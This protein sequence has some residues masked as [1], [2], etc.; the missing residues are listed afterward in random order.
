MRLQD[1]GRPFRAALIR[2]TIRDAR[3]SDILTFSHDADRGETLGG[4]AY[5]RLLGS[6][7]EVLASDGLT[8]TDVAHPYSILV[9]HKAW[10]E[11]LSMNRGALVAATRRRLGGGVPGE[12]QLLHTY[13][14]L[15]SRV[16]PRAV[17]TIGAPEDLCRAA[18]NRGIPLIEVL[19]AQGYASLPWG[20]GDR[21]SLDLPA[22]VISFDSVSTGT[23]SALPSA[24]TEIW[25]ISDPWTARFRPNRRSALPLE[26]QGVFN[27]REDPR[28]VV[29]VS[30]QWGYARDHRTYKEFQGI[31]ANGLLPDSILDLI[32]DTV[33][34]H[35]WLL[36]LHPVQASGSI[37]RRH[38]K[39][40]R[41]V[42]KANPNVDWEWATSVPLP[43]ALAQTTHHITMSSMTTYEASALGIPSL[44]LCPTLNSGEV[45]SSLFQDLI[46]KGL[47]QKRRLE[48][49][50][51]LNWLETARGWSP[52]Q[53]SDSVQ[54]TTLGFIE[55]FGIRS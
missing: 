4:R 31:L 6:I 27:S 22:G 5:G 47:A 2:D 45:N 36:R 35:Y 16:Q 40:L 55:R 21:G 24:G 44:L 52:P 39:F 14:D 15:L 29:L 33:Q 28:Q 7:A 26:W 54:F 13:D 32:A 41:Q 51:L 38:R 12:G 17:L 10:G 9:G 8:I 53:V 30:L 37:S 48:D 46:D 34:S 49:P 20:W 25:Q 50:N 3:R 11:P 19:H 42:A 43:V 1:L 23:F 18:R